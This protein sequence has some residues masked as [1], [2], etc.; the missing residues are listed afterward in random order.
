MKLPIHYKSAH[1][2]ERKQARE[3]YIKEQNGLCQH[4]GKPLNENPIDEV[5]NAYINWKLF[6]PNFQKYPIH[7][8]H[9]HKTGFTIGAIHMK[10]N[11]YLWQYKGE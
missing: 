5:E 11:A 3:Q 6:P 4:C 7:L 2:T 10:C 9:N 8:H 1:W